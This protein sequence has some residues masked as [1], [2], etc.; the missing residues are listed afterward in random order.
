M[1]NEPQTTLMLNELSGGQHRYHV[2]VAQHIVNEISK[3]FPPSTFQN[4]CN[5]IETF[6]EDIEFTVCYLSDRELAAWKAAGENLDR[7]TQ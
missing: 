4:F 2:T 7:L 3:T 5:A 1:T 6:D